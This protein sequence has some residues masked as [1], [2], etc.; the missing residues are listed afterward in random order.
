MKEN[1]IIDFQWMG[2]TSILTPLCRQNNSDTINSYLLLQSAWVNL[3]KWLSV[4]P[5]VN[6]Y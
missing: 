5:C 6:V 1:M 4:A 2:E 3:N